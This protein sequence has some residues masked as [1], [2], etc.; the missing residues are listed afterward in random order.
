MRART[1]CLVAGVPEPPA[2]GVSH[3]AVILARH[4]RLDPDSGPKDHERIAQLVLDLE[5]TARRLEAAE[6]RI[7]ALEARIP[8]PYA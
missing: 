8:R 5:A 2:S 6:A 1:L 3:E 4:W 7:A